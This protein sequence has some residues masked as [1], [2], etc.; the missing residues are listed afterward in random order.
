VSVALKF[1]HDA[2]Q[3]SAVQCGA[4]QCG[5]VSCLR[6]RSVFLSD[7]AARCTEL[8]TAN[9]SAGE[10]GVVF[11]PSVIVLQKVKVDKTRRA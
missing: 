10:C 6:E 4:R 2:K 7:T 9:S 8:D 3:C 11:F 1:S 5:A